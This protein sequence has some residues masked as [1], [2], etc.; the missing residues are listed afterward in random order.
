[1]LLQERINSPEA[2]AA[3]A[4]A[5]AAAEAE[6]N[7]ALVHEDKHVL[8]TL[9]ILLSILCFGVCC[10]STSTAQRRSQQLLQHV[11]QEARRD[12]RPMHARLHC[13]CA[14]MLFIYAACCCRSASIA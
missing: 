7:I 12:T 9:L 1:L 13:A 8:E 10:R 14:E 2:L 5:V 4:A 6:A 11:D 3:A